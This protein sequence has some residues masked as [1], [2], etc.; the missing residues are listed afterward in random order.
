MSL[1][2][3]CA[4]SRPRVFTENNRPDPFHETTRFPTFQHPVSA[5]LRIVGYKIR[6][7]SDGKYSTGGS[8]PE[9]TSV[10]K[11]WSNRGG[12]HSHFA[13]IQEYRQYAMR[14]HRNDSIPDF[15]T[16]TYEGCEIVTLIESGQIPI[17]LY[18]LMQKPSVLEELKKAL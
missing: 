18:R 5:T 17:D 11:T 15:V 3:S 10:G 6:R 1:D 4:V 2:D 9:F 12:L 13:C 7:K 14:R 8:S 16:Q